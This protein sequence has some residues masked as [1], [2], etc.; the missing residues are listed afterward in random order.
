MELTHNTQYQPITLA[1]LSSEELLALVP[2][3]QEIVSE[4]AV[5]DMFDEFEMRE[6]EQALRT[7]DGKLI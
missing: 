2:Y 3:I 1:L 6:H 7:S 4:R 5:Q